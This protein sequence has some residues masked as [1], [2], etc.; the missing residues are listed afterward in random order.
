M[1]QGHCH[2]YGGNGERL[3]LPVA[4]PR[5]QNGSS[6]LLEVDYSEWLAN[7]RRRSSQLSDVTSRR[8][9]S[10]TKH[11][12]EFSSDLE[13]IYETLVQAEKTQ[14]GVIEEENY[15]TA[16]T[17]FAAHFVTS[18]MEE[19]T[20]TA[21]QMLPG[22]KDFEQGR[23]PAG[24]IRP[25]VIRP[26]AM[27]FGRENGSSDLVSGSEGESKSGSSDLASWTEGES[28]SGSSDLASG[29]EGESK[30][31][32]SD[33]ASGTERE[34]QGWLSDLV[35]GRE[36]ENKREP[37]DLVSGSKGAEHHGA[38]DEDHHVPEDS[39]TSASF[40]PS[41]AKAPPRVLSYVS[42]LV[43]TGVQSGVAEAAG[44]TKI[45]KTLEDIPDEIYRW[46]AD[47]IVQEVFA[48][49]TNE[50]CL[51]QVPADERWQADQLEAQQGHSLLDSDSASSSG[52]SSSET[53]QESSSFSVSGA[54]GRRSCDAKAPG[55]HGGGR[56]M[57]GKITSPS[58]T[59]SQ[60]TEAAVGQRLAKSRTAAAVRTHPLV[61]EAEGVEPKGPRTDEWRGVMF[62]VERARRWSGASTSDSS[63]TASGTVWASSVAAPE[64]I[65]AGFRSPRSKVSH[66]FVVKDVP[67]PVTRG[68][69]TRLVR[70]P[71]VKDV[72]GSRSK[73]E[74]DSSRSAEK[75]D[76]S[77]S[78][79]VSGD[80][81]TAGLHRGVGQSG[82]ERTSERDVEKTSSSSASSSS[83]LSFV[84]TAT[85]SIPKSCSVKTE[86]RPSPYPVS[87]APSR[88][89]HAT[90]VLK[91]ASQTTS[92]LCDNSDR[93]ADSMHVL[94][95][96][97]SLVKDP[98]PG[99]F[100][101]HLSRGRRWSSSSERKTPS[102][103]SNSGAVPSVPSAGQTS[104]LAAAAHSQTDPEGP[105]QGAT[106]EQGAAAGWASQ[107]L[108]LDC[109]R[110]AA[111][112][113]NQVFQS[114]PDH[115]SQSELRSLQGSSSSF[116]YQGRKYESIISRGSCETAAA[117]IGASEKG[118]V[119]SESHAQSKAVTGA[120]N[121]GATSPRRTRS[122]SPCFSWLSKRLSRE[123][124]TNAFVKVESRQTVKSYERRSSEP[125]QRSVTLSL[126]A[127]NTSCCGYSADSAEDRRRKNAHT[128][129]DLEN[130]MADSWRRGSLDSISLSR[131]RSS[132]GF[133]DPVLSRFAQEL[134]TADTSVPQLYLVDSE[135]TTSTTG[136]RRSSL[137]GFRDTTLATFE[138]ELLNSSFT[139][140]QATTSPRHRRS[141]GNHSRESRLW[142]SDSSETEYWFPIPRRVG[143]EF[144]E[145][146]ELVQRHYSV[147][148]VEDYADFVTTNIFQ[149]AVGLL[150][151]DGEKMT[152]QDRDIN[153]FSENLADQILRSAMLKSARITAAT[154]SASGS[155]RRRRRGKPKSVSDSE[156]DFSV[157]SNDLTARS[158]EDRLTDF[159]DAL[160]VSYDRVEAYAGNLANVILS[161]VFE[162][163]GAAQLR[164]SEF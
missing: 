136:S 81:V 134:I 153:I 107:D 106:S 113:V 76:G 115:L 118:N 112:I 59:S 13:E 133:K 17:E 90:P 65:P 74:G 61:S 75:V 80:L 120:A 89:P 70:S 147:D 9:S 14:H 92:A 144:Q 135:S 159:Q 139:L 94:P 93:P 54:A 18:L 5:P 141:K 79:G 73:M 111:A 3:S 155:I 47:K 156:L 62:A 20:S 129:D 164:V 23:P 131:R 66:L 97:D 56:E 96:L 53:R 83:S 10:S 12:S 123:T 114:L 121:G 45:S 148:E 35:S 11:S 102:V 22:M 63:D 130:I 8:S 105:D 28:K 68:M 137:S 34:S 16:L 126:Q 108:N 138:S 157:S 58:S 4:I 26:T 25:Q 15:G 86:T 40:C 101:P 82:E 39:S 99:A 50:L 150:C 142:K 128:D 24:I 85:S 42:S 6:D 44:A 162:E 98:K 91:E 132:C 116:Y 143:H 72:T 124:L 117:V 145:Q 30:S 122:Q 52:S 67:V 51:H 87:Q 146:M 152:Q 140:N 7:F 151:D 100:K 69:S 103:P 36:G 119:V 64:D 154:Y 32:S 57:K 77:R 31:G 110:A 2:G 88:P 84:A 27:R 55:G 158:L 160:D 38:G 21:A 95:T 1:Q 19:G 37:F 41:E 29:T 78:S 49:V 43:D 163:F 149:Q 46:F 33:L 161:D 104:G 127:F 109:Y 71:L 48:H 60:G 125:C